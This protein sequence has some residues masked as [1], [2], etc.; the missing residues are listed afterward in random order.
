MSGVLCNLEYQKCFHL[1]KYEVLKDDDSRVEYNY[2]LDHPEE[3]WR[4]YYRYYSR[5][6]APKV[7][8]RI[9]LAVTITVISAVQYYSACSNYDEAIK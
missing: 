1:F 4:N 6:L 7:D 8:V 3:M 9:V 2:M 5:R